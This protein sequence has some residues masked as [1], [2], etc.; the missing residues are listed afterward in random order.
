MWQTGRWRRCLSSA[1]AGY[2]GISMWGIGLYASP[3]NWRTCFFSQ[4]VSFSR[5]LKS[6][7]VFIASYV[8]CWPT[9]SLRQWLAV[10]SL[11][12][13]TTATP[14]CSDRFRNIRHTAT[15]AEQPGQSRLPA[16]RSIRCQSTPPV[17]SLAACPT[18]DQLQDGV[19]D[20]QGV[21]VLDASIPERP[22]PDDCSCSASTVV[23]RSAGGCTKNKNRPRSTRLLS[24]GCNNLELS[25]PSDIRACRTLPTF[26]KTPQNLFVQTV[27][28]WSHQRLCIL[29]LQ[30]AI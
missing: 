1:T 24:C 5:L 19:V 21:V 15:S 4:S 6:F 9:T 18:T 20:I 26:K 16:W 2:A 14:S 12:G 22:D 30:G 23:R 11:L 8:I 7:G 3:D 25:I 27:V 10:S 29:G 13:W 28:T 17:A